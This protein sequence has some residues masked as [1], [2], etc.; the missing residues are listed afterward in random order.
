MIDDGIV[1][2]PNLA[3]IQEATTLIVSAVNSVQRLIKCE[4]FQDIEVCSVLKR[5][6][7]QVFCVK[8]SNRSKR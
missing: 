3:E 5:T 2:L 8:L 6:M 7:I 4:M 1:R